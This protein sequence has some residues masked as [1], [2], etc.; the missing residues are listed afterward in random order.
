MLAPHF[1]HKRIYEK[2]KIIVYVEVFSCH[3]AVY[4][5]LR[6]YLCCKVNDGIITGDWTYAWRHG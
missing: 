5:S 4:A 1:K 6:L 3:A 2:A